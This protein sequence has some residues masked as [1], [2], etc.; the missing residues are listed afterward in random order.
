MDYRA[1]THKLL[2]EIGPGRMRSTAYDTAW[3]ARL[4]ETGE[5]IGVQA[6]DWLRENQLP[7]GSWGA[8]EVHYYHDRLIST[9]AAMTALGRCGNGKDQDRLQRAKLGLDILVRGLRADPVGETVGFEMIAPSLLT[10]VNAI[11]LV[12]RRS[13]NDLLRLG[14][15]FH[16][17][18]PAACSGDQRHRFD[19]HT[20]N[21]FGDRRSKKLQ[22]LPRGKINRHV[23]IAFSA[24]MVGTDGLPLLDIDNLQESNG[25]VGHSP[26][27]TAHFVLHVK[28]GEPAAL[29][30]LRQTVQENAD[31]GGTPDVAPFDNFE[32]AWTLWNLSLPFGLMDDETLALCQPHL[33]FLEKAWKPGAGVG[34]AADYSPKD[35]DDSGLVFDVLA[36]YGRLM[37]I[38]TILSYENEDHFRCYTLESNPSISANIHVLG[39]LQQAGFEARHPAVR[40]IVNFLRQTR[41]LGMFWF[42]KW[43]AS[44]YYPT[45]HAI[46]AADTYDRDMLC[47]A[48]EWILATQNSDGSWGYYTPSAEETAYC[49]QALFIW[50]RGGNPIP[51][52]AIRRG[53]GWLQAHSE[54]PY[55][56]LWIGKSLYAPTLVVRSAILSALL[57]GEQE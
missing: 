33:D 8:R 35:G 19:D 55:P 31:G 24:E 22:M 30:Y 45:T 44:P 17:E 49:L 46:I 41:Y 37:D 1:Q 15:P 11:G 50:K 48:V 7:D 3:I 28:P 4:A 16:D 6:L 12:K 26:S 38:E 13:D 54:P 39:A 20:M 52:E 57:L 29:D 43:H 2:Q 27:A 23:T 25:S 51:N 34:F 10:E 40:K 14:Y 53:L 9:L 21:H 32:R 36:R 47:R 18:Q 42:D 56:P 5:P